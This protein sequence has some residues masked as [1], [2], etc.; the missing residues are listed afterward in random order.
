MT[1]NPK[2]A[3]DKILEKLSKED[4][5]DFLVEYAKS[6]ANLANAVNVRFRK[7]E[8]P[9]YEEEL[10]KIENE[11]DNAL[12]G[13][14][15]YYNRDGWGYV[16]FDVS[17]I[18]A[19]IR[20]RTEQGYIR[21]AFSEL[22]LLYRK[23]LENFEYQGECEI[24]DEAKNCLDIMSEVADKAV[25]AEDKDY[26]FRQCIALSDLEDGKDYGADYEDSLLGIAAKFVT[27]ENRAELE[28][29]LSRYDFEATRIH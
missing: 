1:R 15:S 5:I 28:N 19:E 14:S 3:I 18:V 23:L 17:H 29:V 16:S 20:Q 9:E 22:E 11:I 6:D 25:L 7:P 24:S 27:T 12:D 13:V 8:Y 4:L 26:I 10:N 21:L 2:Q